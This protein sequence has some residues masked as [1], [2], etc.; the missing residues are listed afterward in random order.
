MFLLIN[1][2]FCFCLLYAR[3]KLKSYLASNNLT[4]NNNAQ[5]HV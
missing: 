4:N 3:T 1:M 2:Q 5:V